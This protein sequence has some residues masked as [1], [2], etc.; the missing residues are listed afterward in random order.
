MRRIRRDM[1]VRLASQAGFALLPC[2]AL[3]TPS[4]WAAN[5]T[6]DRTTITNTDNQTINVD[7]SGI[8]QIAGSDLF[9]QI[10]DGGPD[11]LGTTNNGAG[12]PVAATISNID[13]MQGVFLANNSGNSFFV[14]PDA[15]MGLDSISTNGTPATTVSDNGQLA[16]ITF[17]ASNMAG[18]SSFTL[19]FFDVGQN[20]LNFGGGATC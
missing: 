10:N 20:D 3:M 13:M 2:A 18:G 8:E 15:L 1:I 19:Q 14:S 4:A 11:N 7:I 16:A 12:G 6:L 9:V 17:D 5:L